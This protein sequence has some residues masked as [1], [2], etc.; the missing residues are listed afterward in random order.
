MRYSRKR[1]A[2]RDGDAADTGWISPLYHGNEA[3]TDLKLVGG[4]NGMMILAGIYLPSGNCTRANPADASTILLNIWN[5]TINHRIGPFW[6]DSSP[7]F[8]D[9]LLSRRCSKT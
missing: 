8:F 7:P 6:I 5:K 2:R 9:Y 3:E 1:R 4:I